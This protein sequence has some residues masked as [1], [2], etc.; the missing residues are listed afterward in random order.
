M[1]FK[2]KQTTF[3]QKQKP[4]V[5]HKVV[6][7]YVSQNYC[8]PI[9]G[10]ILLSLCLLENIHVTKAFL[11]I[12]LFYLRSGYPITENIVYNTQTLR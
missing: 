4:T 2:N 6:C 11:S 5:A 1:L 12:I 9:S 3:Y 10:D 8:L 7:N